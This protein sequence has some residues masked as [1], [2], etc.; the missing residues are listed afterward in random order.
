M[1]I[2]LFES[3]SAEESITHAMKKLDAAVD[4]GGLESYYEEFVRGHRSP[5]TSLNQCGM[6]ECRAEASG[7]PEAGLGDDPGPSR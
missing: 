1:D 5:L 6:S 4:S 7:L 3:M 2:L